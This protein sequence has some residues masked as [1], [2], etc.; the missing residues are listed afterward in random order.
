MIGARHLVHVFPSFGAGGVPI[1][2]AAVINHLGPRCRHTVVALNGNADAAERIAPDADVRIIYP[3]ID[4]K[5]PLRTFSAI[6]R[7]LHAL[8]P[9]V[10]LTFN[11]GATEWALVDRF[12]HGIR[13]IHFESGFGPEEARRQ[14]RRRVL[15]RRLALGKTEKIVVPSENLISIV[16]NIWK[17]PPDRVQLI[18]NGV[19]C[20]RYG[21]PPDPGALPAFHPG[22]DIVIGTVAPLRP[23][24]NLQRMIA[25]FEAAEMPNTRLLIVGDGSERPGLEDM[26]ARSPVSDRIH[27]AGYIGAPEKVFGLMDVFAMSSDTEQMPNALLQAMAAGRPVVATD[28]GDIRPIVAEENRPFVVP[29]PDAGAYTD[30]MRTL[31]ADADLRQRLGAANRTRVRETYSMEKMLQAYERLLLP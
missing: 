14:K 4:K 28:V 6:S 13:H 26:A 23:E 16:R 15:F 27:F 21:A 24:K 2:I 20:D 18:P 31:M 22:E 1:R 10:L 8:E 3:E 5:H 11:W 7:Q 19:D 17:L 29:L 12:R 25:A 30:A 9:D